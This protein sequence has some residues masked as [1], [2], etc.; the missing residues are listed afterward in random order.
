MDSE[1]FPRY[2]DAW[3]VCITQKCNIPLT[4]E[5]IQKRIDDLS[6][7]NSS[8][9]KLFIGKYGAHWRDQILG[10]FKQAN[11]DPDLK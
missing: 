10:Y 2:Y 8:A 7:V 3:K 1:I 4:K 6:D 9:T 5:Y 11:N